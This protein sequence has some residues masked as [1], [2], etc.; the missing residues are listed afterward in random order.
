MG[1]EEP[2][3]I[4]GEV[5]P[6]VLEGKDCLAQAP[7]GTGKTCAFGL[8]ILNMID[9]QSPYVQALILAPTREL[10]MQIEAELKKIGSKMVG[11]RILSIY[12][13]QNI[14]RQLAGLR[15]KPQIVVGTTGRVMDHLRR[16]TLKIK[17]TSII[18]L[19]EAD[20]MLNMGFR[21]D[22]DTILTEMPFKAQTLLF[23]ATM[24][25]EIM[26]I[27]KSYQVEPTMVKTTCEGMDLPPITQY[28]L[29]LKEGNKLDALQRIIAD[30]GYK[31][32]LIFCNTKRKT[33]ELDDKL[34]ELNYLSMSLHGD[35][36]QR[37]RDKV[38][39]AFRL[40]AINILVATDIAARG[41]DVSGVEAIF[42]YDIPLDE[43]YY[44]H[45][46]GR[47]ARAKREGVAYS[48]ATEKD[49][50]RLRDCERAIKDKMIPY[51]LK[52]ITEEKKGKKGS[53]GIY[54][55]PSIR[56]FI[57]IGEKDGIDQVKMVELIT[58]R[59]TVS[60]EDIFDIK[61]LDIFSFVEVDASV[62]E[63]LLSLAGVKYAK[64]KLAIEVASGR[65]GKPSSRGGEKSGKRDR[66]S[67]NEKPKSSKRDEFSK[68]KYSDKK[69]EN[70]SDKKDYDKK[71]YSKSN[72]KSKDFSKPKNDKFDN[73]ERKFSDRGDRNFDNRDK[74]FSDNGGKKFDNRDKK[75]SDNGGKKFD[76][77]DKKFSDNG[78]KKF[79][80]RDKKFSD[81]GGK[82]FD[83]G[84]KY[85]D[86]KPKS[87]K[88][89][90]N[91]KYDKKPKSFNKQSSAPKGSVRGFDTPKRKK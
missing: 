38:M 10:A 17:N 55:K 1:Y 56:F 29:K 11:L 30:E 32:V 36:R 16:K 31:T 28:S 33:D 46:I 27:S 85:D 59:T 48:F 15:R 53:E 14:E 6:F 86:K 87:S 78:G 63:D 91:K 68:S 9:T 69:K 13:G 67:D 35:M 21:E 44:I 83:S 79:D 72:N 81:N 49:T 4:Q 75:F 64:R 66:F 74:K 20:E 62:S 22:I 45:R 39:R 88:P 37:E 89:D 54:T 58:S 57:N 70:S 52:G 43:E 7:T 47:T 12:G 50:K 80:N 90:S 24:P 60:P 18:V 2:T 23:S 5:I 71:P 3:P 76:N 25:P 84:K 42:N 40:K 77:R 65:T 61:I 73:G 19:D 82:K 51:T 8:P 26:T 41:I 34:A